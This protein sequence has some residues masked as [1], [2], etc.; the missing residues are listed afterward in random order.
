MKSIERDFITLFNCLWYEDFPVVQGEYTNPAGWTIH[1]GHI[2][3]TCA[4]LL[5]ARAGFEQ[6]GR[7]DAV[8]KF[9]DGKVLSN[10]EWEW[11]E[12]HKDTVGEIEKLLRGHES[13]AFSTFI[14]Y[15]NEKSLSNTIEKAAS[16]WRSASRPLIF[17]VV[18]FEMSS[19]NRWFQELKTYVFEGGSHRLYRSQPALPWDFAPSEH[20]ER[21]DGE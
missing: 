9:P 1:I 6:G 19:G 16:L 5:G 7:T 8:L 3:K 4:K 20:L 11:I 14:S 15:S 12:A 17:F 18:T 21:A 2:V 10:V 13:A